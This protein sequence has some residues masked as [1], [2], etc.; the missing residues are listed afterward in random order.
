VRPEDC[1]I[2][3]NGAGTLSGRIYTVELIGDHTLVTLDLGGQMLTLKGPKDFERADGGRLAVAFAPS[4]AY[5]FDERT[6]QRVR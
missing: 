2:A 4:A 5:V 6:G 1:R 3:G